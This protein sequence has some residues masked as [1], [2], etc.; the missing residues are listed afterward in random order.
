MDILEQSDILICD[1]NVL[2][3]FIDAGAGK[4]LKDMSKLHRIYVPT[5]ELNERINT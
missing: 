4:V 1:A 3:D 2:I 5:L